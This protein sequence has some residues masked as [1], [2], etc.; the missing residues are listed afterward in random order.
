MYTG[1]LNVTRERKRP[2][3]TAPQAWQELRNVEE[4]PYVSIVSSIERD[5]WSAA[6]Y[7]P[8]NLA[9]WHWVFD[10]P[11]RHLCASTTAFTDA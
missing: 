10:R 1:L 9:V 2:S 5:Q 11:R 3:L 8:I 4:R 6:A 7:W